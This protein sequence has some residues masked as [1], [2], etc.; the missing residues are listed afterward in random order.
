MHYWENE[1]QHTYKSTFPLFGVLLISTLLV[2]LSGCDSMVP[3]AYKGQTFSAGTMDQKAGK[4][5]TLDTLNDAHGL[6]FS[7]HYGPLDSSGLPMHPGTGAGV[8]FDSVPVVWAS[9]NSRTLASLVDSTTAAV[10]TDYQMINS[11][12]DFLTGQLPSLSQDSLIVVTYPA[13]Q[14]VSYAA[15]K[16]G[17][18]RDIYI[19]TSLMYYYNQSSLISNA[20]D[21]VAVALVKR[22]T[23]SVSFSTALTP[24]SVYGSYEKIVFP[25]ESTPTSPSQSTRSVPVINGRYQFHVDQG[26]AYI[27]RFTLSS[28]QTISNPLTLI[29]NQFKVVILSF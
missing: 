3:D 8:T 5:L 11:K 26:A 12:F 24:E 22:D 17:P 19:Y 18:A 25:V 20:S 7:Y 27:V 16:A 2:A 28:P 14:A 23:S 15:L 21:Y 10:N 6:T 4:L 13:N 1:M 29:A 9:I